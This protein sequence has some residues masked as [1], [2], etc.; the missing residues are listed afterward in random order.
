MRPGPTI[1]KKCSNCTN[2]IKEHTIRSGNTIDARFWTDG[3]FEAPM[4]PNHPW[5]VKCPHC[6]A[7]IWIDEQEK[8]AEVP[9]FSLE[10]VE[11]FLAKLEGKQDSTNEYADQYKDA[12]DFQT[13]IFDEYCAELEK[14]IFSKEKEQYI[15]IRAWRSGNDKRRNSNVKIDLLEPEK[16]NMFALEKMLDEGDNNSRLLNAEIKRELG[17]FKGALVLLEKPFDKK[18]MKTV[19]II[20]KLVQE[21]KTAVTEIISE[22]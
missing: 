4:L 10:Q 22:D 14:G 1:I 2:L 13:P 9:F 20:K 3:H 21:Y 17:D 18:F 6:N 12:K 16:Q 7:L 19:L 5:L 15:R 11:S 8:I